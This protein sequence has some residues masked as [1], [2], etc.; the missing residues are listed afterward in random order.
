M[1]LEEMKTLWGEMSSELER[2]KKL[3]DSLILQMTKSSYR[4]KLN[5]IW[6][7]ELIGTLISFAG[8]L[9]MLLH[10][11]KLNTW[12]LLACGVISVLILV[13]LPLLSLNA[14]Y[15]MRSVNIS[16]NSYK[17]SLLEYSK[18]KIQFVFVQKLSFYLS[19]VL[20]LVMLPVMGQLVGGVDF[21]KE[22]R[23]WLWY[24]VV[25][26]SF[27]LLASRVFKYYIKTATN[28]ENI[29]KELDN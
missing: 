16:A 28:A 27:Y 8:V 26:V 19:F 29:L 18:G 7:P 5:K 6:I 13:I 17:Q 23:I 1:E 3:T 21:F 20:M 24:A 22:T 25:F 11:Q 14:V 4:N 10:F 9:F 12:Y 2:Q 15:K